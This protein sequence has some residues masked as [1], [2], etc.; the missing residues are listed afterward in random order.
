M[1]KLFTILALVSLITFS[2]SDSEDNDITPSSS[3]S[4]TLDQIKTNS[5]GN[6]S[7]GDQGGCDPV[8]GC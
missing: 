3:K 5:N 7:G 2:C 4:N 1:K 8:N 6:Q